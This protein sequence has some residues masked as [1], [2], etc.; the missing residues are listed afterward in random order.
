[1]RPLG[2]TLPNH[3]QGLPNRLSNVH[4]SEVHPH[5]L[6]DRFIQMLFQ[7]ARWH[8]GFQGKTTTNGVIG[9]TSTAFLAKGSTGY[10]LIR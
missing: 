10:N 2:L 5:V 9:P 4:T 3:R 1:M 8:Q 7:A 6:G